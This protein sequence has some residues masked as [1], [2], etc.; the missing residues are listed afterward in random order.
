MH[1]T[2]SPRPSETR[3]LSCFPGRRNLSL[4]QMLL[5]SSSN[6]HFMHGLQGLSDQNCEP[7]K[8]PPAPL[9]LCPAATVGNFQ[10]ENN[11][12]STIKLFQMLLNVAIVFVQASLS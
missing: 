8:Q 6:P 2:V 7:E 12:P 5:G 10:P 3:V 4:F 1:A 11:N 9:L